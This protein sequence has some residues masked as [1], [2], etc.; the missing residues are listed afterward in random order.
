MAKPAKY[1]RQS[2]FKETLTPIPFRTSLHFQ[3]PT[4]VIKRVRNRITNPC[5]PVKTK[6]AFLISCQPTI[7]ATQK[8]KPVPIKRE[9]K[10]R[11][12]FLIYRAPRSGAKVKM[13][14]K[15]SSPYRA[16]RSGAKVK[17]RTKFSSPYRAPRS[18]TKVKMRT[19]FS[20]PITL[21][22]Y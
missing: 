4:S 15:F 7:L 13:R 19:K 18:G 5:Q 17:M 3:I 21:P 11:K 14:T 1:G 2:F 20:S 6:N 16:P 12:N 8:N 9:N 10:K 22:P